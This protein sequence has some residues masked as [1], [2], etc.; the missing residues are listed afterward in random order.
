VAFSVRPSP[1]VP[2]AILY[3]YAL[4]AYSSVV[5]SVLSSACFWGKKFYCIFLRGMIGGKKKWVLRLWGSK[6][7]VGSGAS[8]QKGETTAILTF[9][10]PL[11]HHLR[12]LRSGYL[13]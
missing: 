2:S 6:N 5:V 9:H 13:I 3:T 12:H 7:V 10:F 11:S 4:N 1:F 8:L